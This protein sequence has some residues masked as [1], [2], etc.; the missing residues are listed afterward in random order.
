MHEKGIINFCIYMEYLL[1][2]VQIL[3]K[4]NTLASQF[5]RNMWSFSSVSDIIKRKAN[6]YKTKSVPE[7]EGSFFC[8][9]PSRSVWN[10]SSCCSTAAGTRCGWLIKIWERNCP[11]G[12]SSLSGA[13]LELGSNDSEEDEAALTKKPLLLPTQCLPW[14]CLGIDTEVLNCQPP[15]TFR[16]QI[17]NT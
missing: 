9:S 17:T 6:L 12:D 11:I 8:L 4:N 10:C 7:E 13:I 5:I 3:L 16:I 1:A 15:K 2:I 14:P